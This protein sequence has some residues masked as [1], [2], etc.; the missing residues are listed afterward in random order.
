MALWTGVCAGICVD[1]AAAVGEIR[2]TDR[3]GDCERSSPAGLGSVLVEQV[4]VVANLCRYPQPVIAGLGT[5]LL[6]NANMSYEVICINVG[7]R[8]NASA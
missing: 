8:Q 5:N 6:P 4:H 2:C 3:I 7:A 1:G